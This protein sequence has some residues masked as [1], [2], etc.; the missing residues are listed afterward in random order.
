MPS[1]ACNNKGPRAGHQG[2]GPVGRAVVGRVRRGH[3]GR[4]AGLGDRVVLGVVGAVV[5]R[6]TARRPGG[7]VVA[8]VR[9]G[10]R[11]AGVGRPVAS[12]VGQRGGGRDGPRAGHQGG[13]PVGRAVVG[14]VRRGHRGRRA[15]LGDRVVL[16]VVG[17]VVVRITARRPGGGVVAGVR[18]GGRRAGVGRPVAS[19]V[20]QRGGGRDGPRAGHQGGGPVGRAVVGRVRRGHRGRRA[21][22]GDRV[23]LG[24]VGAVVV[25]ITARRPGGGVVAGVRR[26]CRRAGVGRPVASGVGQRGGGRDGPRAGH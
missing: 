19:G 10:G 2:G 26:I 18:R 7:G 15:G 14:R 17:A 3:R 22:L 20:G 25:R 21:G 16:G 9:R 11:R 1:S 12:G 5:V 23:V 8:G 24:V 4:R 6:I 13:G